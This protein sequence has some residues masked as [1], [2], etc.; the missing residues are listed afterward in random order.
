[1]EA[2]CVPQCEGVSCGDD[3]CGGSCGTCSDGDACNGVEVC[4]GGQCIAGDAVLCDDADACNGLESCDAQTGECIAGDAVL[5]DDADA[6]NGLESCDAQTGECIAGDAVLCD[7]ADA[8]NGLESCDAQTGECIAGDAVL[9]DDADACN[10]LESCDAQTGECIAGEA[11]VCDDADA[12]NGLESCDASS[13][14]CIAGDA[15]SCD[16]GDPCNGEES[17]SAE[18]GCVDGEPLVCDDGVACNGVEFCEADVGCAEGS[19]PEGACDDANPCTLDLCGALGCEHSATA[20]GES[21]DDG[22]GC[23]EQDVCNEGVCAGTPAPAL[24]G[25]ADPCTED[26][27]APEAGCVQAPVVGCDVQACA[28]PVAHLD[29]SSCLEVPALF[30]GGAPESF[31]LEFWVQSEGAV[32]AVLL[33]LHEA[34]DASSG[35][36]VRL[37]EDG[38][39]HYVEEAE[40]GASE[41]AGQSP[42]MVG[43]WRHVAL[44]RYADGQ[45]RFFFDGQPEDLAAL[46]S[47]AGLSGDLSTTSL[48]IGCDAGSEGF[49]SGAIDELR[50]STGVRYEEA[51]MPPGAP[52]EADDMTHLLLN[53]DD[54]ADG[55]ALDSSGQG[56]NGLWMGNDQRPSESPVA[57]CSLAPECEDPPCIGAAW[58]SWELEDK[59]SGPA[60]GSVYG[61]DAFDAKV[62]VVV[63]LS[64]S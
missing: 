41:V 10:G 48:W 7:D 1:M 12:C 15:L 53:F 55:T 24:C 3:G 5:C 51:F 14:E 26:S 23:T 9:C 52:F 63:L 49:F 62:T 6:C 2:P 40:G 46:D 47:A 19:A 32:D 18:S 42:L 64:A 39:L 34:S 31:T 13:G 4:D 17:C 36:Q 27:C 21:C 16:D 25:D 22:V 43:T 20:E 29:G 44:V 60:L 54:D 45:V 35:F 50:L 30:G 11:V 57:D 8:C 56:L 59:Q 37:S 28:T 58:P 61:L 38:V 33:D